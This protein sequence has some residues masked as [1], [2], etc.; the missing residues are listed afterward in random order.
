MISRTLDSFREFGQKG[1]CGQVALRVELF[2]AAKKIISTQDQII[3]EELIAKEVSRS[4]A[5]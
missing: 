2:L 3:C 1:S 5:T 4:D